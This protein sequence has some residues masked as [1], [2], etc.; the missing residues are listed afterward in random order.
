MADISFIK[1]FVNLV[2]LV[3]T[4]TW[5]IFHS[6]FYQKTDDNAMKGPTSLTTAELICRLMNKQQCSMKRFLDNVYFILKRTHSENLF[7]YINNLHQNIKF[8]M[9]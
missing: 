8:T 4:I 9:E 6:N 7:I 3:L 5:Y 1:L 2:N